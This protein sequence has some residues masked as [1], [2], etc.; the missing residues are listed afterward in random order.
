MLHLVSPS[1]SLRTALDV[2]ISAWPFSVHVVTFVG[3]GQTIRQ[4]FGERVRQLR[5]A[6]GYSQEAFADVCG[7]ARSYMSRVERGGANPSLDAVQ[8]FAD[9]LKVQPYELFIAGEAAS[10]GASRSGRG[11]R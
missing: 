3:L 11:S 4:R 5:V 8:V 9:A 1:W 2:T 6:A 10:L 7:F